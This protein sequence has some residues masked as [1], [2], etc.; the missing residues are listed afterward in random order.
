MKVEDIAPQGV[1]TCEG[2][3][4]NNSAKTFYNCALFFQF[5]KAPLFKPTGEP[6]THN[7]CRIW[8][9]DKKDNLLDIF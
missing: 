2:G 7:N 4:K 8:A 3:V 9:D 6:N 5:Q 1:C